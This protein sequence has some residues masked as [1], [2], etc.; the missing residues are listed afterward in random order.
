MVTTYAARMVGHRHTASVDDV[1]DKFRSNGGRITAARR[2]IVAVL[3]GGTAHEHL[4]ADEIGR[5][6]Q[7]HHPEIALSTVYRSL[8][9]LADLGVLEHVHMGHG[10]AV[11][12]LVDERHL[13]LV[14][15]RCGVVIEVD[16][17]A[18]DALAA[19]LQRRT[20]FAIEPRHFAINGLCRT[21]RT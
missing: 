9:A 7:R 4:T 6:V 19:E 2:E 10:P 13:H 1:L 17:S 8:E 21:C 18:L 12:H 3:L 5:R 16:D 15:K 11:Y 20:G 14:C